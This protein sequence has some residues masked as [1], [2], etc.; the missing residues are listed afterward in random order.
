MTDSAVATTQQGGSVVANEDL[1][2]LKAAIGTDLTNPQ[3]RLALLY[4][5]KVGADLFARQ[6]YPVNMDG[7]LTFITSIDFLRVIAQ[8]SGEY[9]G[10]G[11]V[12]YG[13]D[14]TCEGEDIKLTGKRHP[15]WAE[16]PIYREGFA[17]PIVRRAYF[18][19]YAPTEWAK[20]GA[21]RLVIKGTW[22]KMP[23]VLCAKVSEA[24]G[25][26]IAFPNDTANLYTSEEMEQADD[27]RVVGDGQLAA[28]D[29]PDEPPPPFE[30]KYKGAV[31]KDVDGIRTVGKPD[32]NVGPK[33]K[34]DA[35]AK[36]KVEKIE[37]EL[38]VSGRKHTAILMGAPGDSLVDA[39]NE[40]RL[41][42]GE[43]VIVTGDYHEHEW[44]Q[45]KPKSKQLRNVSRLAVL[46]D[47]VWH[48]AGVIEGEVAEAAP[49]DPPAGEPSPASQPSPAEPSSTSG[50]P[51]P[52]PEPSLPTSPESSTAGSPDTAGT[53]PDVTSEAADV[54]EGMF[55]EVEAP[56]VA[57]PLL[58]LEDYEP[59]WGADNESVD[60]MV[61]VLANEERQTG[62]GKT[63]RHL[64]LKPEAESVRYQAAISGAEADAQAVDEVLVGQIVRIIGTWVTRG[65]EHVLMLTA[66]QP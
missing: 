18:H 31:K 32:W 24:L 51:T 46:R 29:I 47:N 11:R 63:Y 26:R 6:I 61:V 9:R 57:A 55:S 28:G 37:V 17:E 23:H 44:Q 48:E 54:F 40:M 25:I 19:E 3:L 2:T 59:A 21:R 53:Q 20:E 8:R 45:G 65:Q 39:V 42:E 58:R 5:Q 43:T 14:C 33:Y 4:A 15:E 64:W 12:V 1:E 62:N 50:S 35:D 49:T 38:T 27:R 41:K 34:G 16:V 56:V 10:Q 60:F 30:S 22:A 7:R 66:V 36:G 13:D 52:S